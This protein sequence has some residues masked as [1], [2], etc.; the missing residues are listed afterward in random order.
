M[1]RRPS[2]NGSQQGTQAEGT[3]R[4]HLR[5]SSHRSMQSC[6]GKSGPTHSLAWPTH[7]RCLSWPCPCG[8]L[9]G[10]LSG[11]LLL[12]HQGTGITTTSTVWDTPTA[13]LV[14]FKPPPP[15]EP[16]NNPLGPGGPGGMRVLRNSPSSSPE[17]RSSPLRMPDAAESS[18]VSL[19][20]L[21]LT[22]PSMGT[23]GILNPNLSVLITLLQTDKSFP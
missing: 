23:M 13:R 19:E 15:T 1:V 22:E 6:K 4:C 18:R 10:L 17:W 8:V 12:L 16:K 2:D 11:L 14:Y 7:R 5:G 3:P 9:Q 21:P 20:V